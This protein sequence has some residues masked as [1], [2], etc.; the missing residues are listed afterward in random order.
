MIEG[1]TGWLFPPGDVTAL[2]DALENVLGFVQETRAALA[3]KAIANV[4]ENFSLK[5]MCDKT[6]DVYTEVL[7]SKTGG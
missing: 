7:Q 3:R 2:T 6:L 5:T 1:E 4:R